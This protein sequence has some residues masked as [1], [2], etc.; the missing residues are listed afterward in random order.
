MTLRYAPLLKGEIR[1]NSIADG[2]EVDDKTARAR[3]ADTMSHEIRDPLNS[4]LG[5]TDLLLAERAGP[6]TDKQR[7]YLGYIDSA[8]RHLL[9]LVS[10]YLDL[11]KLV[12][13]RLEVRIMPL[14]VR[15]ILDYIL[16]Q[17]IPFSE[18][19]GLAYRLDA[20][21]SLI[22]MADRRRLLQILLNLNSNA[23]KHTPDNG[24]IT[25]Q[26][27]VDGLAE[28]A[29]I[30]IRDSGPGIPVEQ[31][32]RIFEEFVQ[33][34]QEKEGTGLGLAISRRLARLMGGELRVS[35]DVGQGSSFTVSLP[36]PSQ[37]SP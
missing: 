11:S 28:I 6:L 1:D 32:E 2:A 7:R 33:G 12:A 9:A 13:D 26:A 21:A 14:D 5:F 30:A 8:S 24:S 27:R 18:A 4:V 31:H 34:S 36:L 15:P 20:P 19:R 17:Q 35:S 3:L 23:A 16:E 22:V 25:F 37:A 29:E 10:D